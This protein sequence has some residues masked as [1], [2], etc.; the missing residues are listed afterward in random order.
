MKFLPFGKDYSYSE[1][2]KILFL[3]TLWIKVRNEISYGLEEYPV[4]FASPDKLIDGELAKVVLKHAQ[5]VV[6]FIRIF[7]NVYQQKLLESKTALEKIEKL[8]KLNPIEPLEIQKI[9]EHIRK[10]ELAR[11]GGYSLTSQELDVISNDL[12]N[13]NKKL[14]EEKQITPTH[15]NEFDEAM[16]AIGAVLAIVLILAILAAIF[17]EKK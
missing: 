2:Y 9:K 1:L 13:F 6:S 10:I 15:A 11:Y 4:E 12:S 16:K 17:S 3:H 7:Y 14:E 8:E 5:R